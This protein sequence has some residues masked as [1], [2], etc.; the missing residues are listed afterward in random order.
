MTHSGEIERPHRNTEENKVKLACI[1]WVE[2]HP[3][4]GRHLRG[5]GG[6]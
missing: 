3:A 1:R 2:H 4:L 5:G 6:G